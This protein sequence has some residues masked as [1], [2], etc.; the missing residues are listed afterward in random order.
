V[1]WRLFKPKTSAFGEWK[2]LINP[3]NPD[4]LLFFRGLNSILLSK[5]G[6]ESWQPTLEQLLIDDY[7]AAPLRQTSAYY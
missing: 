5:D 1:I 6:G 7:A 2:L 4:I 3:D